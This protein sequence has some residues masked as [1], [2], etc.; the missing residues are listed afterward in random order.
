M[1]LARL[2]SRDVLTLL[3]CDCDWDLGIGLVLVLVLVLVCSRARFQ[4]MFGCRV[5]VSTVSMVVR[6]GLLQLHHNYRWMWELGVVHGA[7]V[8]LQTRFES[9][10]F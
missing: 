6:C 1:I 8:H 5:K 7:N 4:R 2:E 3:G 10:S 9:D